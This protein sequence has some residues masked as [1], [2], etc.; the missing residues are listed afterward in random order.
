MVTLDGLV[1]ADSLD[2]RF[3]SDVIAGLASFLNARG[4]RVLEVERPVREGHK[5][6]LKTDLPDAERAARQ[7]LAGTAGASP[8][9][10]PDTQGLRALLTTRQGAVSACTADSALDPAVRWWVASRDTAK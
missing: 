7:V 5:G 8:R 4:E 6:R 9:L 10:A 1:A 2:E 3:S